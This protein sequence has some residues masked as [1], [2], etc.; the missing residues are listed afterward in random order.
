MPFL[1]FGPFG[2]P[3]LGRS[4]RYN[5]PW[6]I[7]MLWIFARFSTFPFN[8]IYQQPSVPAYY[9]FFWDEDEKKQI[10]KNLNSLDFLY[11][12][13]STFSPTPLHFHPR[14]PFS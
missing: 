11:V 12:P 14:F 6:K 9:F 13:F 5:A 4:S 1:Q 7:S 3:L 2:S 10:L 8:H